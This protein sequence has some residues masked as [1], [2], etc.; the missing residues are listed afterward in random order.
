MAKTTNFA[1]P[2]LAP[3]Q[4]Q[5]HVTV[6]EALVRLDAVTQLR[7]HASDLDTPPETAE[8]GASYIVPASAAGDWAGRFGQ[9]AVWSNGGWV[10]I[11]PVA[12]W[13]AWHLARATPLVYDGVAWVSGV[14]AISSSGACTTQEIIEFDQIVPA[15]TSF[16]TDGVIPAA[17][18]V[19]GVTARVLSEISG[20]LTSWRA[21]VQGA[22]DRY[23]TGLG[24][25]QGSYL[26]G[27]TGS[28]VTYYDDAPL[29]V[30]AESGA[31]GGGMVRFA[32]HLSRLTPPRAA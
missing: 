21:G 31:F 29:R 19:F 24:L 4:A 3:A 13:R 7:I 1:L 26:L 28:P 2:L 30:G 6:N 17:S 9:V 20:T 25:G 18:L 12:G 22:D 10:Y 5:K 32:I 15:G 11:E 8:N 23:G 27:L 14:A 16:E